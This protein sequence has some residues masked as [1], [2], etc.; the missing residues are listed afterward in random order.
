MWIRR[1]TVLALVLVAA[2]AL[3]RPTYEWKNLRFRTVPLVTAERQGRFL[4]GVFPN[5][6]EGFG[7]KLAVDSWWLGPDT[8]AA[9]FVQH[10]FSVADQP[11]TDVMVFRDTE[12]LPTLL[13][14]LRIPGDTVDLVDLD[15]DA[16]PEVLFPMSV[17]ALLTKFTVDLSQPPIVD[18]VLAWDAA[19]NRFRPANADHRVFLGMRLG[20]AYDALRRDRPEDRLPGALQLAFYFFGTG[21][22]DEG[23]IV[24]ARHVP[25]AAERAVLEKVFTGI[26]TVPWR[27]PCG[28]ERGAECHPQ[29]RLCQPKGVQQ[30]WAAWPKH[31][32][33]TPA[34]LVLGGGS[35]R[36]DFWDEDGSG[37]DPYLELSV[38][39]GP[40][41]RTPPATDTLETSWLW[42]TELDLY[43]LSELKLVV[44]DKDGAFDQTIAMKSLSAKELLE[45]ALANGGD[46]ELKLRSVRRL[47]LK[48][49]ER[50]IPVP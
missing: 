11:V 40:P 17:S 32:A 49:E 36:R 24:L 20:P 3:A 44:K 39:N 6:V 14:T 29:A 42:K 18:V 28:C 12:P 30:T 31:V 25:D 23:R 2:T 9:T 4:L 37:P 50:P 16:V 22:L 26:V 45:Q 35:G 5:T 19:E 10:R 1:L 47:L 13:G 33:V 48:V 34:S 15:G 46:V 21:Q 8:G 27:G 7:E 43:P 41:A 38:D